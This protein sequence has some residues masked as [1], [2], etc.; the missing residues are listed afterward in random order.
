MQKS[1]ICRRNLLKKS[2]FSTRIT[3]ITLKPYLKE[4]GIPTFTL[5]LL[6]VF[7]L[8]GL[9]RASEIRQIL[10]SLFR[11]FRFGVFGRVLRPNVEVFVQLEEIKCQINAL[12]IKKVL[13][14]FNLN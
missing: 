3:Q 14:R 8:V 6:H 13:F 10:R 7:L 2:H 4:S 11:K 9:L 5:R 1:V 12:C